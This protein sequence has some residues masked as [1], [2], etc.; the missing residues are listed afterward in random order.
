MNTSVAT[1]NQRMATIIAIER[2]VFRWKYVE[3]TPPLDSTQ[4]V[5]AEYDF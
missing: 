2:K 4:H 1:K 5:L 3:R